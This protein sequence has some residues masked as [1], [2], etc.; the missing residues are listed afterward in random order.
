MKI[1]IK[2]YPELQQ[3]QISCHAAHEVNGRMFP[4]GKC[5]KCRRIIGMVKA[6]DENPEK[7]GYNENQI[8]AGLQALEKQSV[9]QIGSDAGHLYYLLL[10]K[11][12]I[13]Q[14]K[15][16]LKVAKEHPEITKLRFDKERSNLEDMPEYIRKP[17][18]NIFAEYSDGVVK[19]RNN[20]WVDIDIDE[21]FL[22]E[23]NY[24][25]NEE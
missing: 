5:E 15:F 21:G 19:R 10:K 8:T 22:N 3:H 9:K 14:N 13:E 11:N 16:T 23:V 2:R 24:K 1:L 12:L 20:R 17:L 4:C 7:C 6:L 25:L 18:F